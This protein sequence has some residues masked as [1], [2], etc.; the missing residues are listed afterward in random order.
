MNFRN[1]YSM[2]TRCLYFT[3]LTASVL[4]LSA[5][6]NQDENAIQWQLPLTA[7][8]DPHGIQSG[9][10]NSPAWVTTSRGHAT[11]VLLQKST[12]RSW[13]IPIVSPLEA[14]SGPWRIHLLGLAQGLRLKDGAFIDDKNVH[15][16]AALVELF[17]ENR[18]VYSGWLYQQFPEMFGPDSQDW[19]LWLKNISI[20][21]PLEGE[22]ETGSLSSAG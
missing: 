21:I 2:M 7:P 8:N 22:N 17:F 4:L 3:A 16:P 12:A 11:I 20:Q 1:I 14:S 5:C 15:N 19:K 6:N 18:K 13:E 9:G 10:V